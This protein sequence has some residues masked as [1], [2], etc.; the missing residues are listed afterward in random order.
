[1]EQANLIKGD[2][3]ALI[4]EMIFECL[5]GMI[6]EKR[7]YGH[8]FLGDL[9]GMANKI[10]LSTANSKSDK[11]PTETQITA[12]RIL[13]IYS[14]TPWNEMTKKAKK[15]VG[16]AI[17]DYLGL[18]ETSGVN[19]FGQTKWNELKKAAKRRFEPSMLQNSL[20]YI[21]NEIIPVTVGM[22][23]FAFIL[24]IAIKVTNGWH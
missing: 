1:M 11:T 8:F 20:H 3:Q 6:Q 15:Q 9:D 24:A 5:L 17:F 4:N 13:E 7:I 16:K 22:T 19:A 10:G 14:S 12:Q 2:N 18:D 21:K 23:A